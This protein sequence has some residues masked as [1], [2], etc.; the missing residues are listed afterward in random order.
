MAPIYGYPGG[1][2][3]LQAAG[4]VLAPGLSPHRARLLVS[5]GLAQSLEPG[6]VRSL[7]ELEA[8]A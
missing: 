3:T 1:V 4:A 7:I 2:A 6:E 8:G 5:L